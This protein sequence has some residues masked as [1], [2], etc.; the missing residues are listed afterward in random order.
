MS[1]K[2][3]TRSEQRRKRRVRKKKMTAN[4]KRRMKKMMAKIMEMGDESKSRTSSIACGVVL[5]PFIW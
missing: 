4:R 2:R 3:W 5:G 1:K